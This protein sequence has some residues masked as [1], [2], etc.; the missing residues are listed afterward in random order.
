MKRKNKATIAVAGGHAKFLRNPCLGDG[1]VCDG[2]AQDFLALFGCSGIST[3]R[4]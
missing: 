1:R 3:F 4:C 2:K